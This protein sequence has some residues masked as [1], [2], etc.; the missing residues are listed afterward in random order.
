MQFI[1]RLATPTAE[2]R[3]TVERDGRSYLWLDYLES[4]ISLILARHNAAKTTILVNDNYNKEHSIKDEEHERRA[5]KY[6]GAGNKFPKPNDPFP[7]PTE[8]NS[9]LSDSGNKIRLQRLIKNHLL[10][11]NLNRQI[12][13]CEGTVCTD[14]LSN[15]ELPHLSLDHTEADSMML[16]I[17]SIIR[18]DNPDLPVIIDS[19]DTDVY[20]QAAY[21][22]HHVS[23][24]LLIKRKG[25]L[26]NCKD[27]AD[28]EM[29]NIMIAAHCITGCDHTSGQ[30]GHGKIQLM[31]KLKMDP[32]ARELLSSVGMQPALDEETHYDME[33]FI[34]TKLYGCLSGLT[35]AEARAQKW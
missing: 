11:V 31:N 33:Q 9:F 5:A 35:C 26:V 17:Y 14:I 15:S 1:W 19:G 13:Y 18:Q 2:D 30:Y 4:V 28:K 34:L 20:V 16:T 10:Q 8:F 3:G 6:I 7:S 29:S 21:V 24:D 25:G 32:E 12:V 22:A 23:G 27:L